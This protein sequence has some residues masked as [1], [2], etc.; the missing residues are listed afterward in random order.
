MF[1]VGGIHRLPLPVLRRRLLACALDVGF[2]SFDVAPSYGDGLNEVELGKAVAA[3]RD[4]VRIA[5]KFGIPFEPYGARHPILFPLI[6]AAKKVRRG[7]G[8]ERERREFSGSAMAASLNQSLTR[9]RTDYVDRFLIHEPVTGLD[10][11][12]MDDLAECAEKLRSQGKI[13]EFGIAGPAQGF[14]RAAS[15]PAVGV[16]QTLLSDVLDQFLLSQKRI[17]AF[18]VYRRFVSERSVG[19]SFT[20]FVRETLSRHASLE[21]ILSSTS[22]RTV[23]G[24]GPL[25]DE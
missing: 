10:T 17:V 20:G 25:L 3:C 12:T 16:V 8:R 19:H 13:R 7:Y 22:E 14:G 2:R 21:L 4:R 9:L 18:G 24:Y 5:T 11:T 15:H 1:G 23:S 6:R